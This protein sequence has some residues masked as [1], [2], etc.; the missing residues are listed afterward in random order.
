MFCF[1]LNAVGEPTLWER[2][3]A[4]YD[5]SLLK[6]LLV[7]V[8]QTYFT[9]SLGTYE[10]F[11]FTSGANETARSLIIALAIGLVCAAAWETYTRTALGKFVRALLG[12][13]CT[14]PETAKTLMELGFFRNTTIRRELKRGINLRKIVLCREKEELRA[15]TDD[16]TGERAEKNADATP[17]EMD[18]LTAHFYIPQDLRYRA[19]VRFEKKGSGWLA[20]VGT[21]ILSVILASLLCRFLPSILHLVDGILSLMSP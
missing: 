15:S 8:E 2:I 11:A 20:L 1:S 13:E 9:V 4:W 3:S 17:Y 5:A 6:E 14:S 12:Q 21:A 7:Y 19:E 10:N 16:G 18:L